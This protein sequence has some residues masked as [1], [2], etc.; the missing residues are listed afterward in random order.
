MLGVADFLLQAPIVSEQYQAFAVGVEPSGWVDTG[1]LQE[2]RQAG[3]AGVWRKLTD[4][5]KRFVEKN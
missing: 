4:H 5:P 2:I 1:M 3:S